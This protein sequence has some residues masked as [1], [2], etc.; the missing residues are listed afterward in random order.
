MLKLKSICTT[1]IGG[2]IYEI[3]GKTI[4]EDKLISEGAY[5]FVY[6]ANDLNTNKTYTI[7]KTI[8]QNKEKLEMAKK[9]INI[10]KSLPPHK[11]IVQYYGS[12][13]INE[14]NYKIV[15]MLM[16]Y[17]ERGN[18]LNIFEKNKDKIKEFHIIKILKDIISG[19]NFLHTQ[20]IPIIHRDIKLENILCDK[21]NVYKICDFCSHTVSK[22]FFPNDLKK[23]ELN[24]LKYEIERDTTIYYRPPE[25]IDLY[26]NGEISTKVDIWMVGCILYLLLFGFHPFQ[27]SISTNINRTDDENVDINTSNNSFLSILNGS[28]VIPHV[29]KYSKRIISILL[30]TLDKN[31]QIR[32]S[33]STLLLILENYGDLKSWFMHIPLDIKKLVN[34]IFEKI[35]ELNIN[36]KNDELIEVSSDKTINIKIKSQRYKQ[37]SNTN[38]YNGITSASNTTGGFF[39]YLTPV[40]FKKKTSD[41][42]LLENKKNNT[43]KI[44]SNTKQP[45]EKVEE[46]NNIPTTIVDNS[47]LDKNKNEKDN[48]KL[49]SIE[50]ITKDDSIMIDTNINN[51]PKE[52]TNLVK[53]QA[54]IKNVDNI[55]DADKDINLFDLNETINTNINDNSKN[56]ENTTINSDG[57]LNYDN[58]NF[59]FNYDNLIDEKNVD[60]FEI[61]YNG[62]LGCLH[63]NNMSMGFF[64]SS[65]S[66]DKENNN[67]VNKHSHNFNEQI[68]KE[69]LFNS[70]YSSLNNVSDYFEK[71]SNYNN[72]GFNNNGFNNNGFNNNGFNNNGFNN[73]GYFDNNKNDSP[74]SFHFDISNKKTEIKYS[75]DTNDFVSENPKNKNFIASDKNDKFSELLDEF[76]KIS[77][78]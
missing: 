15:I 40:L 45:E 12:T 14:N 11:N 16:E 42:I 76:Q 75:Y 17:C 46:K 3:N 64:D 61:G 13:I 21:N 10:L 49:L 36:N 56:G 7:K 19:L 6:L 32:I 41:V 34:K 23:N 77:I 74:N 9:E 22:S 57:E 54:F 24:L 28:F 60:L 48:V 26:S 20:E 25:L 35:N 47:N 43:N 69:S 63:K 58:F 18:L 30:M 71:N 67:I 70:D 52:N 5:S 78:K 62:N 8:C 50:S 53:D 55:K 73:M 4:K 68:L 31:P 72:N 65:F 44:E 33:S 38:S 37:N 27:G 51:S 39:K 66:L 1:L 59:A 29:T 2:K